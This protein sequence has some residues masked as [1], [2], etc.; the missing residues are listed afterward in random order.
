MKSYEKPVFM[1]HKAIET[2]AAYIY[3][4]YYYS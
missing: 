4:Y 2:A 1:K 3:Y